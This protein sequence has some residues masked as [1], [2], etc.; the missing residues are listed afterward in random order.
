MCSQTEGTQAEDSVY[1]PRTEASGEI[2]PALAWISASQAPLLGE[3]KCLW[4]EPPHLWSFV[5]ATLGHQYQ[6]S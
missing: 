5:T 4:F 2:N 1:T 3:D 6:Y